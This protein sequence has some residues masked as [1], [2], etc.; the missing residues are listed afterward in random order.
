MQLFVEFIYKLNEIFW[1]E[2][3]SILSM[4]YN[5]KKEFK[6]RKNITIQTQSETLWPY[7]VRT[8]SG[9]LFFYI[10]GWSAIHSSINMP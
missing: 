10:G 5:D 1:A 6:K 7:H 3:E 8:I 9:H 4:I 2:K